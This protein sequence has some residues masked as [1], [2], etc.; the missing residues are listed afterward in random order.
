MTEIDLIPA[1]Y[2]TRQWRRRWI[3]LAAVLASGVLL[4]SGVSYTTLA[5]ATR[6]VRTDIEGLLAQ[7]AITK[8]QRAELE[9]LSTEKAELQQQ[10]SLLNGLRS[11]AAAE[12]M[13][14]TIE[15]TM[16]GDDLWFLRW[17]FRRAG[18]IVSE[19]QKTVNTGYFIVV[20]RDPRNTDNKKDLRPLQVET[21]MTIKGQAS[22]HAALSKF[23]R[24][25]FE[26]P[27]IADVRLHKTSLRRY[28]SMQVVDFDLDVVLNSNVES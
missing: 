1:D 15:R 18:V 20:P 16:V 5:Y 13:F 22:D 11:G 6:Q 28:A 27:E 8:Q 2:R 21:H 17:Q 25:L 12:S 23:V 19:T 4:L 14:W 3:R 7:Q 9:Q 24:R 10:L 26:Q